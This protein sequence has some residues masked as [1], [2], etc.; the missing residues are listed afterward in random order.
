M[1]GIYDAVREDVLALQA[2]GADGLLFC[3]EHDLPY[4]VGVGVEAAGPSAAGQLPSAPGE[5]RSW[6]PT[7]C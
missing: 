2:A 4:S 5:R 1:H 6:A 7:R 3:N